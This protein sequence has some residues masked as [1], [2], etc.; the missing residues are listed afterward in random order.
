M[1]T[2]LQKISLYFFTKRLDNHFSKIESKLLK[3]KVSETNTNAPIDAVIEDLR[4][5]QLKY[6]NLLEKYKNISLKLCTEVAWKWDSYLDCLDN[7]LFG[8][9]TGVHDEHMKDEANETRL[10]INK[11]FDEL[12][13]DSAK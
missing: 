5:T 2:I 10:K 8:L 1:T 3:F 12:L 4:E 6:L 7:Y 13:S 9:E 11:R